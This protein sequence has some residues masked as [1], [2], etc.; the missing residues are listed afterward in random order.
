MTFRYPLPSEGQVVVINCQSKT[1]RTCKAP[2]HLY[3]ATKNVLLV[4]DSFYT[5]SC[6][7]VYQMSTNNC[8]Y[9]ISVWCFDTSM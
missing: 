3:C 9:S 5:C 6:V 7:N 4:V 2:I 8:L 1:F